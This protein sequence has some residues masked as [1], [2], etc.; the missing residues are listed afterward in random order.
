MNKTALSS[1]ISL[2]AFLVAS[3]ASA[4]PCP[5]GSWLCAN[6]QI[7]GGV[8]VTPPPPPPPPPPMVV[9][10]AQPVYV[11]PP[12]YV[13]TTT[14]VVTYQRTYNVVSLGRDQTVGICAFASG[15]SLGSR[16]H[17]GG[18]LG[19]AVAAARFRYHP[20]LATEL[21]LGAYAGSDYNGDSRAEVPITLSEMVYFNPQ[22]RLQVYGLLGLGGSWAAVQYADPAARGGRDT[23]GYAY[24]GGQLGLGL[25]WQITRHFALFTDVRAFLRTR[26]DAETAINPEFTR[27]NGGRTETTNTSAGVVGNLGAMFYF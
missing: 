10:E 27:T 22:H 20:Y 4:Q 6:L 11:P 16:D 13:V 25:E 8:T 12:T 18:G 9:V 21:T 15:I 23:G 7:G 26:V 14:P 19:G 1:L 3:T 24:I 5:P 17:G 2:G